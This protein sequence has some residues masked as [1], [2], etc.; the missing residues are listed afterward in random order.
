MIP[1]GASNPI[2]AGIFGKR[3]TASRPNVSDPRFTTN[4]SA[5]SLPRTVSYRTFSKTGTSVVDEIRVDV[6]SGCPMVEKVEE[7][8]RVGDS[9]PFGSSV[10][11][12]DR[13]VTWDEAIPFKLSNWTL[14]IPVSIS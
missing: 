6:S 7:D 1:D 8:A 11:D 4:T 13:T 3:T 10:F 12:S 9:K 5:C 2:D 14:I